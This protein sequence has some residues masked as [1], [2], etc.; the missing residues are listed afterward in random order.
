VRHATDRQ[1]VLATLGELY[2]RRGE[3]DRARETLLEA[4]A[5]ADA[6]DMPG[7]VRVQAPA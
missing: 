7:A 1:A 3:S 6:L 4:A 5:R 2:A